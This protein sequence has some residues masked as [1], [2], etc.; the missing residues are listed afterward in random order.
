MKPYLKFLY[1]RRVGIIENKD[2]NNTT[3]CFHKNRQ[4]SSTLPTEDKH[5]TYR[6]K[7]YFS[8]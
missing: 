7:H 1:S 4:M 2:L 6:T 8:F 5:M 3:T